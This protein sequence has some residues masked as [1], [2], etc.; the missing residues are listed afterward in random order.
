M[1]LLHYLPQVLSGW[2]LLILIGGT[3]VGLILGATPGLSP[4]M[5]VAL[6]IPFTFKMDATSGL[7]LLG[8]LYTSTVA[9]GAVSAI[10]IN[11]PGAPANIATML[12]GHPMAKAGK[13][14]QALY[15]CFISSAVGGVLGVLVLIFLTPYLVNVALKFGPPELFWT[16]ILGI[17]VIGSLGSASVLKGLLG[18]AIGVWISLIGFNPVTG[19]ERFVFSEHLQGGI[20]IIPALIGLF[21]IPQVLQ[22]VEGAKGANGGERF[23]MAPTSVIKAIIFNLKKVKALV[24]GSLSG[25]IVG[26]IP[27]AGG[28]IAGLIAYDQCKKFS[29]NK[30]N[31]GKGEPEGIIAAESA[32]NA[33]VGASLVPM[34]SLGIPGSPTAAVLLGGLL[35]QGLFPGPD[36]FT[37]HA[38]VAW[39]FMGALLISQILLVVCGLWISGIG[40]YVIRIPRHIMA[41]AVT[42]LAIFGTYSVQNSFSDVIIMMSMGSL[43]YFGMQ[44]GFTPGPIVLGIILGPIAETNFLQSQMLAQAGDGM[45]RYMFGGWLNILLVSLCLLSVAYSLYAS[46]QARKT[47]QHATPD[48][49][50]QVHP[51]ANHDAH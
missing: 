20:T 27:G 39:T 28:Q 33:M 26:I 50:V 4:T 34:L 47:R 6:L 30:D 49:R 44:Y 45:L 43:M 32:N 25:I 41:A 48:H 19:T 12:D 24:I 7:I 46:W 13:A 8:V 42:T 1:E 51:E 9:G 35:I 23:D 16:A 2:N 10:L 17:T 29:H 36:L 5:A 37:Q 15:Y 14:T 18:G 21:A 40:K 38:S 22:M 3:I 11:I 31:F